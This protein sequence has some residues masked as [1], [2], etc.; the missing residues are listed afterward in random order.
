MLY[1]PSFVQRSGELQDEIKTK[2]FS[3]VD[4]MYVVLHTSKKYQRKE[5]VLILLG[6][7]WHNFTVR[8]GSNLLD[9]LRQEAMS[10]FYILIVALDA[11]R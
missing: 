11:E 8:D 1:L 4:G 7:C 5:N 10:L 2:I 9:W 6:F 3:A